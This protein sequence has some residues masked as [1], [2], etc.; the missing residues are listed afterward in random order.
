[1]K[2]SFEFLVVKVD[3][4][5]MPAIHRNTGSMAG[6]RPTLRASAYIGGEGTLITA[7]GTLLPVRSIRR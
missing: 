5:L 1:M 3:H 7:D 2:H 6:Q 4:R